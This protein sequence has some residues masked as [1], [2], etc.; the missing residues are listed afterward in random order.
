MY[1]YIQANEHQIKAE[2]KSEGKKKMQNT[3][4]IC[5][6]HLAHSLSVNS[7]DVKILSNEM[8]QR[9]KILRQTKH[10]PC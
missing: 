3:I 8:N 5:I 4:A 10:G 1:I 2:S 6:Y 7:N 9:L